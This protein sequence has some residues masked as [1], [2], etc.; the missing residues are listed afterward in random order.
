MDGVRCCC[1]CGDGVAAVVVISVYAPS[2]DVFVFLLVDYRVCS[3]AQL[4]S[5]FVS[6]ATF[7]SGQAVVTGV[8]PSPPPRY[9][10][11][12]FVAGNRRV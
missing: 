11:F 5:G 9:L 4:V 10:A 1:C 8:F 6:S 12:V 2:A 7:S 3:T